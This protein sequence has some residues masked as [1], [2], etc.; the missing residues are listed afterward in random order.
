VS[1]QMKAEAALR[2]HKAEME[3]VTGST[4]WRLTRPLRVLGE[5]AR[6]G[7]GTRNGG[8]RG[9]DGSRSSA[10]STPPPVDGSG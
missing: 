1:I 7:R 5:R 8:A 4:S 2:R 3:E 9:E 10:N 6:R